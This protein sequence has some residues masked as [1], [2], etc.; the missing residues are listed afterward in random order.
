ML[1]CNWQH[2]FCS[3]EKHTYILISS[4]SPSVICMLCYIAVISLNGVTFAIYL[5]Q[6]LILSSLHIMQ[7]TQSFPKWLEHL[8]GHNSVTLKMEAAYSSATCQ[9]SIQHGVKTQRTVIRDSDG[10]PSIFLMLVIFVVCTDTKSWDLVPFWSSTYCMLFLNEWVTNCSIIFWYPKWTT[11]VHY[12][13]FL[14]IFVRLCHI[15]GLCM[16]L[17]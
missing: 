3:W 7:I 8:A 15:S 5:W 2:A 11:S 14:A 6:W 4:P 9:P 10:V 13:E 17:A 1:F 12:T 16:W